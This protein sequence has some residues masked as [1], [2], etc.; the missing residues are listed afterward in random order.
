[1]K[2]FQIIWSKWGRPRSAGP[3]LT[4]WNAKFH[5][6]VHKTKIIHINNVD[7]IVLIWFS[8]HTQTH[9]RTKTDFDFMKGQYLETWE[10]ALWPQLKITVTVRPAQ[11]P[12][13]R[14]MWSAFESTSSALI[15]SH[16]F[17]RDLPH[18]CEGENPVSQVSFRSCSLELC[19][20]PP[21]FSLEWGGGNSVFCFS[22]QSYWV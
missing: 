21:G 3:L 4:V 18:V 17:R 12:W 19:H 14:L 9:T 11:S 10:A 2:E 15:C 13:Q 5:N 8:T 16:G 20:R 22:H 6:C 7:W 1:M